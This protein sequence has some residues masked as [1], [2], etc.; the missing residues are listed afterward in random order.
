[1]MKKSESEQSQQSTAK[2]KTPCFN[3]TENGK[4]VVVYDED[5]K[6]ELVDISITANPKKLAEIIMWSINTIGQLNADP[7]TITLKRRTQQ[8]NQLDNA[9][10]ILQNQSLELLKSELSP[11]AVLKTTN[12]TKE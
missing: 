7:E 8:I 11:R 6:D 3:Y 12:I 5:L 10:S 1:M 4:E 9:L 2:N